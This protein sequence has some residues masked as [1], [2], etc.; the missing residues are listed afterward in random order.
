MAAAV[1]KAIKGGET[2][3]SLIFTGNGEMHARVEGQSALLEDREKL[4]ELWNPVASSWFEGID[5]PDIRLIRFR[6]TLRKSGRQK[7]RSA[8]QSGSPRPR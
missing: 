8:S 4:E 1:V 3:S 5:D 2:E 6:R 7:A